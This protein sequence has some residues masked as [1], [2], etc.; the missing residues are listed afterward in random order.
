MLTG[1]PRNSAERAVGPAQSKLLQLFPKHVVVSMVKLENPGT[2]KVVVFVPAVQFGSKW[3]PHSTHIPQDSKAPVSVS[4][5]LTV[6]HAS[7]AVAGQGKELTAPLVL[8]VL[9]L[10]V[11]LREA[12]ILLQSEVKQVVSS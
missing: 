8:T 7:S 3:C 9:Q 6:W 10:R 5:Y 4:V 2:G 1:E 12:S 11:D